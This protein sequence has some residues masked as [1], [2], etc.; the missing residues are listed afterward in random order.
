MIVN[1]VLE[2]MLWFEVIVLGIS[3][4]SVCFLVLVT[5]FGSHLRFFVLCRLMFHLS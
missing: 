2:D 3:M 4:V 1:L 5:M